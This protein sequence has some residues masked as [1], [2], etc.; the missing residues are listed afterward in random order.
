M[1]KIAVIVFLAIVSLASFAQAGDRYYVADEVTKKT[2]GNTEWIHRRVATNH[3]KTGEEILVFSGEVPK[4]L[5]FKPEA[6]QGQLAQRQVYPKHVERRIAVSMRQRKSAQQPKKYRVVRKNNGKQVAIS[7]PSA[8]SAMTYT[9]LPEGST[10]EELKDT[11]ASTTNLEKVLQQN[12]LN[13]K[14]ARKLQANHPVGFTEK[15]L[16]PKYRD[17][18]PKLKA[19][20]KKIA[21][22]EAQITALEGV[23]GEQA[24]YIQDLKNALTE[25]KAKVQKLE[26]EKSAIAKEREKLQEELQRKK[27]DTPK[28]QPS[29]TESTP[30]QPQNVEPAP[31]QPKVYPVPQA[32][33]TQKLE[34]K[35][36]AHTSKAEIS[37]LIKRAVYEY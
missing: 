35:T 37:S 7:M 22:L 29:V 19:A 12:H 5:E 36:E 11:Y 23:K 16:D 3:P 9:R 31:Q 24:G 27:E 18:L 34:P 30:S 6:Q 8:S 20:Y 26:G 4:N 2:A 21:D 28:G 17:P 10:V 25:E 32:P 13:G 33:E 15:Q 14:K 1:K